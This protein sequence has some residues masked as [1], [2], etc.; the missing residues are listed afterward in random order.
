MMIDERH[1]SAD[2]LKLKSGLIVARSIRSFN[3]TQLALCWICDVSLA[4]HLDVDHLAK[5]LYPDGLDLGRL[6]G[7][8]MKLNSRLH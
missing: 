2:A 8:V 3:L 4:C 1:G 5:V 6:V 7:V